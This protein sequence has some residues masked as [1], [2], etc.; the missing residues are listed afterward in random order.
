MTGEP[1]P[2]RRSP[3][4]QP[5]TPLAEGERPPAL[6]VAVAVCA[7]L[8]AGVLA[9]SLSVH[10][11]ARHG[12]SLPGALVLAARVRAGMSPR[13]E[14]RSSANAPR[15]SSATRSGGAA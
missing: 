12:G 13:S 2:A 5:L 7:L 1:A 9:G 14:P 6:I 10:D 4:G 8:A 11:L 15:S 3:G